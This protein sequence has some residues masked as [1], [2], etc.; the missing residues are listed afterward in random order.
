MGHTNSTQFHTIKKMKKIKTI[1]A[2]SFQAFITLVLFGCQTNAQNNKDCA[3][4]ENEVYKEEVTDLS[5][6]DALGY[7]KTL[8][9]RFGETSV[10]GLSNEAYQLQFYSINGFGKS[11]KFEET[12]GGCSISVKC[13]FK[14]VQRPDCK[15]YKIDIEK[16]EWNKLKG[17]IYEFNFW[18]EENFR[19]NNN[20]LDGFV[21]L[22]EG[23]RP[24]AEKCGKK[25]YKLVVRGSPEY[26]KIGALCDYILDYEDRLKFKYEQLNKITNK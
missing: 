12:N 4:I 2:F 16:K 6:K 26:N 22:L 24:D 5:E 20:V 13:M 10:K 8:L 7:Q 15:E 17:M 11:V 3:G 14:E 1:L 25:T 19:M 18:T 9:E 21:F 23:N